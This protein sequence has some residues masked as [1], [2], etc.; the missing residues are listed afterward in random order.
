LLNAEMISACGYLDDP[1]S[2]CA[3]HGRQ[4]ADGSLAKPGLCHAWPEPE[5]VMHPGCAF[6]ATLAR[7]V[8]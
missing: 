2:S 5:D 7:A 3:L 1:G 6:T 4:R 8:E